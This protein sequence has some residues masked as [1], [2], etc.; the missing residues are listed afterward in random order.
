MERLSLRKALI[1]H[2]EGGAP[3]TIPEVLNNK[4]LILELN[5]ATA[6]TRSRVRDE[7]TAII[8]DG[9][10]PGKADK[11]GVETVYKFDRRRR[12]EVCSPQYSKAMKLALGLN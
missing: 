3:F 11:T 8:R 9:E 2:Y 1:K 6:L 4:K 10:L 12:G 7:V 5:C